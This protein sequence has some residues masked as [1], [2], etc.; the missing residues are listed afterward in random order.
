MDDKIKSRSELPAELA[1]LR[2]RVE[3]LEAGSHEEQERLEIVK[4]L[5]NYSPVP[6]TIIDKAGNFLF[7]NQAFENTLY[8]HFITQL[9]RRASARLAPA[10]IINPPAARRTD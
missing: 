10:M 5:M 4:K 6:M 3:E 9:P 8:Q 2:R 7:F 1:I